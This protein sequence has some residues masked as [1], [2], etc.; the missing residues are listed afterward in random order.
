MLIWKLFRA[1]AWRGPF[2]PRSKRSPPVSLLPLAQSKSLARTAPS[3]RCMSA[4]RGRSVRAVLVA[5]RKRLSGAAGPEAL[6][7]RAKHDTSRALEGC[8]SHKQSETTEPRR[9]VHIIVCGTPLET[10]GPRP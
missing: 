2:D 8:A 10:R 6:A 9:E 1:L 4:A 3:H 5:V 7:F